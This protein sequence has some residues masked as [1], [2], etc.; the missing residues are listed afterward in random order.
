MRKKEKLIAER[1]EIDEIIKK[2]EIIRVAM[3]KDGCP[4]LVPMNYGY[5]DGAVYLHCAGEGK[6][7]DILKQNPKVSFEITVDYALIKKG[8][9]CSW[10]SN[11]RSVIGFGKAVFIEDITEKNLGLQAVMEQYDGFGHTFP[12]KA[13]EATTVIKIEIDEITGKK[14]IK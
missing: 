6:K 9:G 8:N 11:F 14:S 2:G 5:K 12:E 10:T 4:Y 7:I 13:V 3:S 1:S